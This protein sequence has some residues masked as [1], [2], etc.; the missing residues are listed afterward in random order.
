MEIKPSKMCKLFFYIVEK[1]CLCK[2]FFLNIFFNKNTRTSQV[3]Y[4]VNPN[5][6][7]HKTNKQKTK[8]QKQNIPQRID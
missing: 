4:L 8:K 7:S 1:E 2:F 6:S 3:I 5:R